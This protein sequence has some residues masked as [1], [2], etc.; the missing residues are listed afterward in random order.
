MIFSTGSSK[1]EGSSRL[2]V[3]IMFELQARA[4]RCLSIA[5]ILFQLD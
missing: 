4:E 2:R 3:V 5:D 1:I